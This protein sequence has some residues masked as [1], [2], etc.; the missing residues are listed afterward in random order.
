MVELGVE[1][2]LK[3]V[4]KYNQSDWLKEFIDFNTNKRKKAKNKFETVFFKLMN[5]SIYGKTM[6]NTRNRMNLHLTADERNA[7]KWFSKP[8]FKNNTEVFGLYMIETYKDEVKLDKPIYVGTTILDLSKLLMMRFHYDVIEKHFIGAYQLLYSDTDSMV[9]QIETDD[10]Y[11]WVKQNRSHF[12]LAES[13]RKDMKDTENDKT[14]GKMKDELKTLPIKSF[15]GLNPKCYSFT[16]NDKIE[17]NIKKCKGVSKETLKQE[18][19]HSNYINTLITGQTLTK[20]IVCSR[21]LKHQ[22]YTIEQ[23]KICLNSYYDKMKLLNKF[24]CVPFGYISE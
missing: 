13:I 3:E 23:D 17:K 16:Y 15:I 9:Y 6:E 7:V 1:V 12:D 18:I 8:S 14:L 10:I 21:S 24:E 22:L 2:K 11:E 5:N 20:K 19:K 4:L